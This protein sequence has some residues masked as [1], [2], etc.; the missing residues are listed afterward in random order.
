[1]AWWETALKIVAKTP[2][3]LVDTATQMANQ[4]VKNANKALKRSDLS[5]EQRS[6]TEATRDKSQAYLNRNKDSGD[7]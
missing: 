4:N 1:M 7:E 2:E 5:D 6:R 3:F